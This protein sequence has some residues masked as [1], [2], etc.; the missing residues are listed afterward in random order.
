[1]GAAGYVHP[2]AG[3]GGRAYSITVN[4]LDPTQAGRV[5]VDAI[6]EFERSNGTSWRS[7]G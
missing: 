5:V 7:A 1:M 4:A 6:R 2:N 3:G